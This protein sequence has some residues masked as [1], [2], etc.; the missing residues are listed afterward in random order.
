[1]NSTRLRSVTRRL[2][3]APP[4]PGG[5]PATD[6]NLLSR[7]LD[8]Q[9]EA[10]FELLVARHLS[11]VRA[12]CRSVLRD[13]NDADDAV[14]ATFLVLIRRAGVVRNREALGG[15]LCRVA[16][17]AAN[18]LRE[19]NSRQARRLSTGIAP[20]TLPAAPVGLGVTSEVQSALTEEI[21]RLP[22]Q[23]RTAVLLC[24]A[25]GTP[26]AEAATRLG[27]PK[28]T[29]L[30]R[31]AWARKRLRDRLSKR[32]VTLAGGFTVAF[33]ERIGVAGG[34][35]LASRISSAVVAVVGG[36]PSALGLVSERVRSLT[37]GVVRHMIGTKLKAVVGIGFLAIGLLGLSLG[38][39][40]VGTADAAGPGDKKPLLTAPP[41]PTKAADSKEPARAVLPD[42]E[43]R[44]ESP[45]AVPP[46][47]VAGPGN[48]LVVR[49]PLGSYT[50]EVPGYGKA[51]LTFTEN[52]LT[53]VANLRI[54]KLTFTVTADA[55]YCMNRE[56]MVYGIITGVDVNG[57]SDEDEAVEIA[58]IL[59]GANDV[60]FAFRVRAEDDYITIKDLKF[61][62]IGSPVL[63]EVLY[64]KGEHKD[65][66][67]TI[68]NIS[69]KYRLDPNPDRRPSAPAL[70]PAPRKN[71]TNS[72]PRA[73]KQFDAVP[74]QGP[75]Q[76]P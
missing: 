68:G 35:L 66:L 16:W 33:A 8:R 38:R 42:A 70:P 64:D 58:A 76:V 6:A 3:A 23:Y 14:Q 15:W 49:R 73:G 5:P 41:L 50:R 28:G 67:Y 9:D 43:A 75:V 55:D 51:T 21:G 44:T 26:T 19:E 74:P 10:A 2:A 56:S 13:R 46:T 57:V 20:E 36:D 27:W 69:G 47:P 37:E 1:M 39:L 53:V 61:G 34:A 12:I 71:R 48:D 30:T 11:G 54:E 60:P 52:R 22:E 4:D 63:M 24:Y 17:R 18:R 45:T 29:L 7:F 65:L 25:A 59:G 40:T 32:G 62:P 72:T 31:L